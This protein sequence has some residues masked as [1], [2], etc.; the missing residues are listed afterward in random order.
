MSSPSSSSST[1]SLSNLA[2]TW[3]T[4]V[5]SASALSFTAFL[6]LH[7]AAPIGA[8]VGLDASGIM[9]LT[10]EYYQSGLLEPLLVWGSL[11]AHVTSSILRRAILGPPKKRPSWHSLTGFLL[12]PVVAGHS[13]SHRIL[14]AKKGVSP[15]LLSYQ[16]VSYSLAKYP[17]TSWL[18][19]GIL[20]LATTYHAAGGLRMILSD[21]PQLSVRRKAARLP[22]NK[23]AQAGYAGVVGGVGI[24][25]FNL[26]RISGDVPAWLGRRYAEV[27][28][29]AYGF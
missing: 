28:Q 5:Q 23:A 15:S 16:F 13:W 3:A 9:L 7:L 8:A 24:G 6:A 29:S 10:R 2:L 22:D 14:P 4:R 1:S 25:L 12:V 26:A 27:L 21:L 19:Y 18:S 11:A 20:T 17:V